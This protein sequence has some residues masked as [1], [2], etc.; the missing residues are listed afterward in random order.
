[1]FKLLSGEWYAAEAENVVIR[2]GLRAAF[3]RECGITP[4]RKTSEVD[5]APS[6][7]LGLL[8]Q[9]VDQTLSGK[10]EDAELRR[11]T[12]LAGASVAGLGLG[13][14]APPSLGLAPE[15]SGLAPEMMRA[16]FT[17]ADR[18]TFELN[19]R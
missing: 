15:H 8:G 14:V 12:Q 3:W 9:L 19:R 1:M 18:T 7:R 13:A 10:E 5:I 2:D 4:A 11:I 17:P 16:F 6:A